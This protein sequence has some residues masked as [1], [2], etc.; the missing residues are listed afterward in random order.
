M[1]ATDYCSLKNENKEGYLLSTC[2]RL[3][4]G[5]PYTDDI[6]GYSL[7]PITSENRDVVYAEFK[8]GGFRYEESQAVMNKIV[9]E[10]HNQ[11]IE[12]KQNAIEVKQLRSNSN[13]LQEVETSIIIPPVLPEIGSADGLIRE[14]C[15][16]FTGNFAGICDL[17]S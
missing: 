15:V 7:I 2:G 16:Y 17:F 11:S 13:F 4:Y 6:N 1:P 12:V 3:F 5:F 14:Y 10:Y 8:A 9:N